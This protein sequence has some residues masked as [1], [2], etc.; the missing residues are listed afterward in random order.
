MAQLIFGDSSGS[1]VSVPAANSTPTDQ[2]AQSDFACFSWNK[3]GASVSS[4]D[5]GRSISW[6]CKSVAALIDDLTG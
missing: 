2:Y 6:Q 3:L 4:E 5:G 1:E